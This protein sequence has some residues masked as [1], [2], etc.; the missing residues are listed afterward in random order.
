[1]SARVVT[2]SA[3][4]LPTSVLEQLGISMVPADVIH[5]G[6][7][8]KDRVDISHDKLFSLLEQGSE[9]P[10]TAAP[11]PGSF[12]E[13]YNRLA[14]ETDEIVSL[15]TT[16]EHSAIYDAALRG[17]ENV[18]Q[19]CRIQVVDSRQISMGLGFLAMDAAEA[20]RDGA[21]LKEVVQQVRREIP[22]IHLYAAFDTMR[23]LTLGG[24]VNRLIGTLGTTL[25]VKL[26]L[27]IRD[28]RLRLAGVARTFPRAIDR[29]VSLMEKLGELEEWSVVYTTNREEAETLAQRLSQISPPGRVPM[30]RLGPGLGVHGGPGAL[31]TV[32]K[33][34]A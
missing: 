11:S 3:C 9:V 1:M 15:H 14:E 18:T 20:A 21:S 7:A 10:T 8:Y 23:Y 30:T 33:V 31:I 16:S 22:L 2:D 26:L 12:T 19:P 34:R 17:S 24:R 32:T 4:D 5:R 27:T 13:V 28:G 29:L 6:H 25:N